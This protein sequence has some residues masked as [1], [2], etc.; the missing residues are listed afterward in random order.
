MDV[1]FYLKNPK[2]KGETPIFCYC[3]FKYKTP[4]NKYKPVKIYTGYS[5]NPEYWNEKKKRAKETNKF[6][7]YPEFNTHLDKLASDIKTLYLK[8]VND[9]I[10]VTPELFKKEWDKIK[11][12]EPEPENPEL[13]KFADDYLIRIA[14]IRSKGTIKNYRNTIG[15]LKEFSR[16]TGIPL[17]YENITL[18]TGLTLLEWLKNEK[19]FAPNT[20]WRVFKVIKLL[21]NETAERKLHKNFDFK[22]KKFRELAPPEE[23]P[24][25][26]LDN[27]DLSKIY[28]LDLSKNKKLDRVRDLFLIGCYTGLRFSDFNKLTADNIIEFEG[29][30]MFN[31][32]IQKTKQYV[33]IPLH[34]IVIEILNKY[35]GKTPKGMSNQK[36][37]DYLKDL[38]ELTELNDTVLIQKKQGH[39]ETTVK[40]QKWQLVTTHTARRS[41]ATNTYLAGLPT[42]SIMKITGHKTEKAFLTY[43]KLDGKDHAKLMA[44]HKFFKNPI[45]KI[46]N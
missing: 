28:N 3:R 43:I 12:P 35:E 20:I 7:Q 33:S 17:T 30:K 14:A 11:N 1:N 22:T 21:M 34:Y 5:I 9:N 39:L 24:S 40:Y 38:A 32:E 10:A 25:I 23:T 8:L 4:D 45:L 6:P 15:H 31:I 46:A 37:N 42:N 36:F 2:E 26:F 19:Q 27:N 18:D 29:E 41:F 13:M 16:V 44:K